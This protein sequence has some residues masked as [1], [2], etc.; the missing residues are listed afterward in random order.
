MRRR[1]KKA[2]VYSTGEVWSDLDHRFVKDSVGALKR[3]VNI[4]SVYTSID[5]IL[6]TYK[7]ERVMLPQFA[8]DIHGMMFE[9]LDQTTVSF[10]TKGIKDTIEAWDN[11]VRIEEVS[12]GRDPDRNTLSV[13]LVFMIQ[14]YNDTFQYE[15]PITGEY[16]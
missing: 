1:A 16:P 4:Q 2:T 6:R 14:G 12:I 7:G 10:L 11:R 13:A 3:A 15:T 8:S 9:T 5:N